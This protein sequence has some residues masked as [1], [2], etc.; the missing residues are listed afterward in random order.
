MFAPFELSLKARRRGLFG[1]DLRS[2]RVRVKLDL[3]LGGLCDLHSSWLPLPTL[4][5]RLSD[6]GRFGVQEAGASGEAGM[7]V[8]GDVNI[9]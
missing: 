8:L 1:E 2:D 3:A 9:A 6:E 5:L 7:A 4:E